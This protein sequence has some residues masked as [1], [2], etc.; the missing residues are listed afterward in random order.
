ML[1][2]VS[3]YILTRFFSG[4]WFECMVPA[5]WK[6]PTIWN[7]KLINIPAIPGDSDSRSN[8]VIAATRKT[9]AEPSISNLN[10]NHYPYDNNVPESNPSAGHLKAP[11]RSNIV[12]Q[13]RDI[14]SNKLINKSICSTAGEEQLVMGCL[15]DSRDSLQRFCYMGDHGRNYQVRLITTQNILDMASILLSSR[16]V[17][18]K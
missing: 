1:F 4:H 8:I 5:H 3:T 16:E 6:S 12:V 13:F 14:V 17:L 15:P 7:E 18:T 9:I 10:V 2:S 11:H